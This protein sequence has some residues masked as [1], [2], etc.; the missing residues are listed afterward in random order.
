MGKRSFT[1]NIHSLHLCWIPMMWVDPSFLC[2]CFFVREKR[3]VTDA[4]W[5]CWS[6]CC[7][8]DVDGL[9]VV[10]VS[11]SSC[12]GCAPISAADAGTSCWGAVLSCWVFN[13]WICLPYALS[14]SLCRFTFFNVLEWAV[15]VEAVEVLWFRS[16]ELETLVFF[17][18][19]RKL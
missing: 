4:F 9:A 18:R 3:G 12:D 14:K 19:W 5:R 1:Y 15:T 17:I 8:L 11:W 13:C 2:L 10:A 7:G 16:P 6:A